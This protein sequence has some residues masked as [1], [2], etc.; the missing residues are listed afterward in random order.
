M[1]HLIWDILLH[2]IFP[3]AHYSIPESYF[4]ANSYLRYRHN[5]VARLYLD[6]LEHLAD[7]IEDFQKHTPPGDLNDRLEELHTIRVK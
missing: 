4:S 1:M 2:F 3:S 7:R 5:Q 6:K